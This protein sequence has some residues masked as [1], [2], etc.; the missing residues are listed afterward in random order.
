MRKFRK[1]LIGFVNG[2]KRTRIKEK[3]IVFALPRE[4][5]VIS[6]STKRKGKL[7]VLSLSNQDGWVLL[8]IALPLGN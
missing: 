5:L 8:K 2:K 4:G 1:R 7:L 6:P 3:V